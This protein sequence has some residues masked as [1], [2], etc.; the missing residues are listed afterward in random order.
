MRAPAA[1]LSLSCAGEVMWIT[2]D[3]RSRSTQFPPLSMNY[4]DSTPWFRRQL[5]DLSI[6]ATPAT[7]AVR[8]SATTKQGF[9]NRESF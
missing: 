2:Q 3:E 8:N 7:A 6:D 5:F 9:Q 1:E 4:L